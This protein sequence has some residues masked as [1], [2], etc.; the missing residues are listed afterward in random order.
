MELPRYT[1]LRR[2]DLV[3]IGPD[4]IKDEVLTV[5]PHK[6]EG[7]TGIT[8]FIP[9]HADLAQVLAATP[10]EPGTTFFETEM[11][12]QRTPTGFGNWFHE[13]CEEARKAG[14]HERASVHGLRKA[15]CCALAECGC[16]AKQIMA[17]SGIKN[18]AIVQKYIEKANQKRL[19]KAG[20]DK[21]MAADR[22]P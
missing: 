14:L 1:A 7:T 11:G 10:C 20:M 5:R 4:D 19:A 6:T 22:R 9:I 13:A 12:E 15:A 2:S 3:R 18:L 8:L 16:T 21:W 17:I